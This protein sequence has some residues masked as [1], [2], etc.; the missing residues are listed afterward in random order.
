M[1]NMVSPQSVTQMGGKVAE[2]AFLLAAEEDSD[3]RDSE[4]TVGLPLAWA[5]VRAEVEFLQVPD[6][7]WVSVEDFMEDAGDM[8]YAFGGGEGDPCF[9]DVWEEVP[10]SQ[11]R[12]AMVNPGLFASLLGDYYT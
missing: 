11:G 12:W 6:A 10:G 3:G 2:E 5:G 1:A 8:M 4:A 9:T 7:T